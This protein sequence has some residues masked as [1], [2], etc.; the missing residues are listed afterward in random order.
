MELVLNDAVKFV[1]N[2]LSEGIID[3]KAAIEIIGDA[4]HSQ[5]IDCRE[6]AVNDLS[7]C[8]LTI[9]MAVEGESQNIDIENEY[10]LDSMKVVDAMK[11]YNQKGMILYCED[12]HVLGMYRE[13]LETRINN[14]EVEDYSEGKRV[15]CI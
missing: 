15:A 13:P 7:V 12:G 11:L 4:V 14:M 5:C 10:P 6:K 3:K 8:L 9:E 2:S 1:V